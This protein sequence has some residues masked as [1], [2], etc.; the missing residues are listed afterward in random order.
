M[1]RSDRSFV[2]EIIGPAGAGKTTLTQLLRNGNN[3]RAGLSVWGLPLSLL[4]VSALSSVPDLVRFC[5][6]RKHLSWEDLKLVVQ[7]NALLRLINR[8]GAKGYQALLLDE[9]NVFALAKLRAFGCGDALANSSTDWMQSLANKVAPVIDAVIWLDAP[10]SVLARRI[11]ERDKDHRMKKKSDA[12]IQKHLSL[13]RSSFERVV[14]ELKKRNGHNLRVFRFST[15]Q[16]P[17]EQ[18]AAKVLMQARARA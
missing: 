8:E 14:D 15:D 1:H 11:R 6:R 13:Y 2:A 12:E 10:D 18:I 17:M 7:H 16:M 5:R 9:G 4:S 3:V